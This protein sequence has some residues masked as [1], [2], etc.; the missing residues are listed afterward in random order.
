MAPTPPALLFTTKSFT[1]RL[2]LCH[3]MEDELEGR[4]GLG[5]E[6]ATVAGFQ[7]CGKG[8]HQGTGK[9]HWGCNSSGTWWLTGHEEGAAGRG[10]E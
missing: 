10:L 9:K 8:L 6:E 2:S 7:E 5:Q 3:L 4:R 1:W